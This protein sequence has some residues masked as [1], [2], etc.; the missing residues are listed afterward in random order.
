[1]GESLNKE[2]IAG[3]PLVAQGVKNQHCLC[4]DVGSILGL[5]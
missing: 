5:A 4:K 1:M 3:V 2:D